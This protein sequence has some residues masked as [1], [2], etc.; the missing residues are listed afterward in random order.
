[1]SETEKLKTEHITRHVGFRL[2]LNMLLLRTNTG[3]K[4]ITIALIPEGWISVTSGKIRSDDY[5]YFYG[6]EEFIPVHESSVGVTISKETSS[7]WFLGN[8]WNSLVI[9]KTVRTPGRLGKVI[10]AALVVLK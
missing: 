5:M 2:D 4:T 8:P 3:N 9:R 1:M 7:A 10:D 6:W